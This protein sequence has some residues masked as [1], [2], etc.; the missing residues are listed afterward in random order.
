MLI[1]TKLA[2]NILI[3]LPILF[4]TSFGLFFLVCGG[5]PSCAH[6]YC[7][8]QWRTSDK[9]SQ[10]LSPTN[11]I[12]YY[13]KNKAREIIPVKLF[14]EV[15]P[16]SVSLFTSSIKIKLNLELLATSKYQIIY[17]VF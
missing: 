14:E 11:C 9:F 10:G 7:Q 1:L 13:N 17:L 15:T 12:F 8:K 3:K 16:V 2:T 6:S 4:K 5:W